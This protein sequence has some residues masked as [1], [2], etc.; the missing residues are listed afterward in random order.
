MSTAGPPAGPPARLE[1]RI[2]LR[3]LRGRKKSGVTALNTTI[4]MAG[5]AIGVAALIVVLGI[6]NGLHD[7]LRDKI[8]V[9][10]PHIHVLTFGANLRLDKW[11]AVLDTVRTD[12]DVVAAAPEVLQK[13]LVFNSQRYAAAVDVVGFDPDTGKASVI[14]LPAA[15]ERGGLDFRPKADSVDGGIILGYRLAN[16]LSSYVG[17]VVTLVSGSDVNTINRA[18]GMPSPRYW[19][20]EV[21]GTFNTGMFQY[22][23]GFAVMRLDVAQQFAGLGSAVSGIQVRAKDPWRAREVA[24]RIEQKLGYPYRTVAWQDQNE[25]LFGALKLEKLGMA[26]VIAFIGVVAAFNIVGTLTMIVSEKTKEIGILLAM[27]LTPRSIKRIFLTQ[28][29]IIGLLGTGSGFILGLAIA[30]LLDRSRLIRINPSVYFIDHLPVH[31]ELLDLAAVVTISVLIALCA[32]IPAS[33]W[34]ARLEPVEAIRH[35]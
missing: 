11:R 30:Y 5:V 20:F 31:L 1:R 12:P 33:R 14:G 29:A 2:A 18:T 6:V 25:S 21:T 22:D 19:K 9:G 15:I 32:T 34:A 8:L 7:D 13:S 4:A 24:K 26:L 17:D 23:D 10:N 27:G 28:G 35:E 3:Y 16:R